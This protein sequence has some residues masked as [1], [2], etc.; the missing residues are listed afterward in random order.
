MRRYLAAAG[1]LFACAGAGSREAMADNYGAIAYS[2]S[3][4][5]YSWAYDFPSRSAAEKDALSR[6][7]T[8]ANDC[9][10]PLWFRNSCGAIAIGS[11]GYGTAWAPERGPAERQALVLC[12]RHSQDCAVKHWVCTTR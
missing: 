6:C 5:A 10:I 11:G 12:Q 9:M 2:P 8:K 1:V 7:R 3:T 4:K